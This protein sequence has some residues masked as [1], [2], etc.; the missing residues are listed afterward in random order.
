[1][2][3]FKPQRFDR[4]AIPGAPEWIDVLLRE[5]N[6]QGDDLARVLGQLTFREN[7]AAEVK[8]VP[9]TGPSLTWSNATYENS[10]GPF[11]PGATNDA[12]YRISH[13]GRVHLRGA[14]DAGTVGASFPMFTLPTGYRP[15]RQEGHVVESNSAIGRVIVKTDGKVCL[16]LGSNVFVFIDG[17]SFD[18]LAPCAAPALPT[19]P[20]TVPIIQTQKV[21]KVVGVIPLGLTSP[22]VTASIGL[23]APVVEWEQVGAG[24]IKLRAVW[25][26]TPGRRYTLRLLLIGG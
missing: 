5:M 16:E 10:W 25:G 3:Q 11:A 12:Q 6:L 2:S 17:I 4:G 18:A 8:E 9:L 1:M 24:A 20:Q 19:W 26:L 13:E 15:E 7:F 22:D 23:G 21:S 14:L